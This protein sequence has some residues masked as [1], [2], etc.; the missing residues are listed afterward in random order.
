[1]KRI[2]AI[3]FTISCV[4]MMAQKSNTIINGELLNSTYKKVT[5]QHVGAEVKD[6]VTADIEK[7]KFT[8]KANIE[9][10]DLYKVMFEEE[11]F[12]VFALSP[13]EKVTL[14]CDPA[15]LPESIDLTGSE[16]TLLIYEAD[17]KLRSIKTQQDS[18]NKVYYENAYS[19]KIDSIKE[20]LIILIEKNEKSKI[21]YLRKFVTKNNKSLA[22][23][24]FYDMLD[25]EDDIDVLMASDSVLFK[26]YP[27]NIYVK[28]FHEKLIKSQKIKVGLPAPEIEL[29]D[30]DGKN[31]KL[32]SLKGKYVLIDFWASWCSPCRKE[33]PNMVKLY[34]K[35]K[36]KGFEIYSVSLDKSKE[37]WVTAIKADNL[38]WTHVSDLKY[39]SS[40]AAREY[41][42]NS[43]PFTI[44][45]DKEG[46]IIAKGLRGE[47]LEKKVS[48]YLK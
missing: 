4:S 1:M 26:T 27:N 25:M 7:G 42:V 29:P 8:I 21:E 45:I 31:I 16:N 23:V 43:V 2:F 33:S 20:A 3:I 18:L 37:S 11:V 17:K 19:P 35:F 22:C 30:P 34:N 5:L 36:D 9:E 12:I 40:E 13:G 10:P 47:A 46:I 48:E 14:K 39:W 41:N 24:F 38:G 15:K 44:L 28:T 6:I 32:S